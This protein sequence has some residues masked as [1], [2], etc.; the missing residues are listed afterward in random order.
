[1]V[2]VQGDVSGSKHHDKL[3]NGSKGWVLR[4]H[5]GRA[6]NPDLLETAPKWKLREEAGC[7]VKKECPRVM[8]E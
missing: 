5:L 3:L 6:P 1:M 7:E 2:L 4:K 8:E